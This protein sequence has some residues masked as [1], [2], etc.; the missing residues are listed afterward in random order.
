MPPWLARL[1]LEFCA[2][3]AD[4]V[5]FNYDLLVER[6]IRQLG[7]LATYEDLYGTSFINRR[8]QGAVLAHDFPRTSVLTLRKLHG[9]INWSY[10]GPDSPTTERIAITN[11]DSAW[12]AEE[13]NLPNAGL[14]RY[15]HLFDDVVPLVVP[16]TG[17]KAAYYG[18]RSVRAQ[19]QQSFDALKVADLVVLIG[20]SFPDSDLATRHFFSTAN[21]DCRV[22]VVNPDDQVAD[23]VNSLAPHSEVR[24]F[25]GP[26]AVRSFVSD[27]CGHLIVWGSEFIDGALHPRLLID[28]Q[29]SEIV[30]D[31]RTTSARLSN[32]VSRMNSIV[33]EIVEQRWPGLAATNPH[34]WRPLDVPSRGYFQAGYTGYL[35][36]LQSSV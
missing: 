27:F 12:S 6:S 9:S 35:S 30:E 16:P 7:I 1:V 10:G 22:V 23:T 19:W 32:D 20:Y 8:M 11:A 33:E 5:S 31:Q 24:K 13:P 18:N 15:R 17:T 36:D 21:L 29:P 26:D 34:N 4:V 25:A 3:S 2:R 14:G 28:G